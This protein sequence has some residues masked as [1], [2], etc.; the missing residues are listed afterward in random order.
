MGNLQFSDAGKAW[1]FETLS[2]SNGAAYGDLD[3]DGDLDLVVNNE[4]QPAFIYKNNAREFNKNNFIS[5]RLKGK[6]ENTFA[7]GTTIKVYTGNQVLIRE[8]IPSRGF[9]S[10]VDYKL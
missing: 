9:Q 1:G 3:N 2:F 6:G 5:V 7:I 8:L 10:S 4:N